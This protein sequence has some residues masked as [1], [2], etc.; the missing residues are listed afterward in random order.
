[1]LMLQQKKSLIICEQKGKGIM[2]I[3]T[4]TPIDEIKIKNHTISHIDYFNFLDKKTTIS[5]K[6]R[7][8]LSVQAY[9]AS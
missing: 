3:F 7:L 1:M 5:D 8:G 6:L 9:L 2:K 4:Q